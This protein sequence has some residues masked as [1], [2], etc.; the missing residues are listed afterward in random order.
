MAEAGARRFVVWDY[1]VFAIMLLLSAGV[2][3]YMAC[4]GGRQRTADEFF[5]GNRKM[6]IFPVSMS[7]VVSF[8]TAMTIMGQTGEVY[9][10]DSMLFWGIF[11]YP[12]GLL[13]LGWLFVP[14]LL[15]L[16][17]TSVYEVGLI[18]DPLL[19]T[20]LNIFQENVLRL[21]K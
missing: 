1:V 5:L 6:T 21:M 16:R 9:L 11:T 2:G 13:I 7:V 17:I 20:K 10:Y 12:A 4:S 8:I 18:I 3:M 15:R 19:Y 14:V